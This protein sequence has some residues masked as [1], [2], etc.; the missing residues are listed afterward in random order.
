[1]KC[2]QLIKHNKRNIS[3]QKLYGKWGK[4]TSSRPLFIFFKKLNMRW[5]QVG[6]ILLSIYFDR[7]ETCHTIEANYIIF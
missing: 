1:M 2:D 4:E 3:L 6:P 5:K 7:S